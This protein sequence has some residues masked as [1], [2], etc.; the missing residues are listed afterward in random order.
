M[1]PEKFMPALADDEIGSDGTD[2]VVVE[3]SDSG[4]SRGRLPSTPVGVAQ[5]NSV[6]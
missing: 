6:P 3:W 4:D 5:L 2:F 1:S